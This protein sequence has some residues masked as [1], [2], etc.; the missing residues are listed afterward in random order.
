MRVLDREKDSISMN[1]TMSRDAIWMTVHG[2]TQATDRVL[3]LSV[4]EAVGAGAGIK[5]GSDVISR[6]GRQFEQK[7]GKVEISG[8]RCLCVAGRTS[9]SGYRGNRRQDHWLPI[10]GQETGDGNGDCPSSS[11]HV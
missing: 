1:P 6:V 10:Q 11:N 4:D 9:R 3:H 2:K 5:A 7:Q 8:P